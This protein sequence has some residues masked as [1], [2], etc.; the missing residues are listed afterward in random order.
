MTITETIVDRLYSEFQGLVYYLNQ[1]GEISFGITADGNFR[2]SLL[3]SAAS[4]FE[5]RICDDILIF[6]REVSYDNERLVEFVKNKAIARQY[7]TFFNWDSQNAN[8][9][10]GLFGE[11]F[12]IFMVSEIQHDGALSEAIRAFM[13]LGRERNRLVHQDYGTFTL[14]KTADEIYQLYKAALPFV[15][16]IPQKLRF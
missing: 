10:F 15:E 13:E 8:T 12:K 1:K 2:K 14:E 11:P 3:L 9:F 5:R 6:T 16:C 4:Y 7:H